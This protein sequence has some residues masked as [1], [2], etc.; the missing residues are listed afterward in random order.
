MRKMLIAIDGSKGALKGVEYVGEQFGG[1]GDLQ[2]TLYQ[3]SQGVPPEWWDDGHILNDLER[4]TRRAVLDKW[5]ANQK[6]MVEATFQKATETLIRNGINPEQIMIKSV[7]EPVANVADCILTEAK[8]GGYQ[9]LVIGR[10]GHSST[11]HFLLGS[12]ASKI[13][14]RGAG[15]AICVVE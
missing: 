10:C 8:E 12:I 6:I 7:Q 13:I 14:N 15:L 2:I 5:L 4:E 9:T 1:M 3:V 11:A